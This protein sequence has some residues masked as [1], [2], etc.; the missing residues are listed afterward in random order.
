MAWNVVSKLQGAGAQQLGL[1]DLG[2]TASV[3]GSIGSY[4]YPLTS[5]VTLCLT[6]TD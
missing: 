3:C 6:R 2:Q 4:V 1:V 5:M